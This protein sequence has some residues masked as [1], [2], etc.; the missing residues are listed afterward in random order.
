[1]KAKEIMNKVFVVNE[2]LSLKDASDL[3]AREGIGC[4]VF[5]KRGKIKGILTERDILKNLSK[6]KKPISKFM[7]KKVI[8][9]DASAEIERVISLMATNKIKRILITQRAKLVGII[10]ATDIVI[11]TDILHEDMF[12]S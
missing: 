7:T 10:T 11:H 1:M 3:M 2:D 9:T 6:L 8:T 5:L 12:F 4:I